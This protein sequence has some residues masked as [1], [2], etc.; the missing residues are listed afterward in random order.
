MALV[1]FAGWSPYKALLGSL[2][3]RA[4]SVLKYYIPRTSEH[5]SAIYNMIPFFA[6]ILVLVMTSVRMSREHA[7]PHGCGTNYF[8]EGG[9]R[10]GRKGVRGLAPDPAQRV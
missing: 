3:F 7:Q 2:V 6:T 1:I 4:L 10:V 9:R 8:R 5:P